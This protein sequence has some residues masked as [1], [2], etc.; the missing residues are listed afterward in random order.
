MQG[1]GHAQ[2]FQWA[3]S[4]GLPSHGSCDRNS[5]YPLEAAQAVVLTL[6]PSLLC[7]G[8]QRLWAPHC[9]AD[10]THATASELYNCS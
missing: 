9:S 1:T 8:P 7:L 4:L 5:L 3:P 6:F 10:G 2:P